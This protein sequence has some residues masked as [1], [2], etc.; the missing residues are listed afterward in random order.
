MLFIVKLGTSTHTSGAPNLST[1]L[2][3]DRF[4]YCDRN[5]NN[6]ERAE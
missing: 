3:V 4:V 2:M 1:S 5:Q 6:S